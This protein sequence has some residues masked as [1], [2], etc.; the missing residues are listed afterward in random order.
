MTDAVLSR[1]LDRNA[2]IDTLNRYATGIDTRDE[3][4]YRS[5]FTDQLVVDMFGKGP[6]DSTA[7]EWVKTALNAV[8]AF[9][10]TQHLIT[11]HVI[12]LDGD[13]ASCVAYLL[14]QHWNPENFF[15]VGGYYTDELV[16]DGEI[17]RMSEIK[18][19]VTW[20]QTG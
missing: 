18:L 1:L 15:L 8:G 10:V 6:E 4:L 12:E 17:W 19:T 16:R 3:A 7:D 2:I 11:N 20:T 14:A 9:R 5:C 13:R